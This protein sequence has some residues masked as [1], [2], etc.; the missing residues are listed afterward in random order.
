MVFIAQILI[1]GNKYIR[2]QR[3]EENYNCPMLYLHLLEEDLLELELFALAGFSKI[4]FP[5][6]FFL[7]TR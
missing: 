6:H 3:V 2:L 7:L 1:Q 5:S 4:M